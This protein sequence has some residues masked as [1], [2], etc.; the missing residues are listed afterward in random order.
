MIH[1]TA[2]VAKDVK[3][4]ESTKIWHLAQIRA[5]AIIGR[6]C[7]VGKNS[8]IGAGVKIGNY[9]KIQNNCSLYEGAE[10]E[11]GVF[12]GPH[13]VLTN[14]LN[15]RA[16]NPDGSLKSAED[17]KEGRILIKKGASIGACSVIVTGVAIGEFALVGAGS[18]VTKDVPDYALTY[19]NPAKVRGYV[20]KCGF[21]LTEEME[22]CGKCKIKLEEVRK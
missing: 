8:Y 14:D 15:P 13:V 2:E 9:V 22:E 1:S 6:N 7:I 10:L 3:I 11:D 21:K 16:I 5:N 17:W 12:I 4:D 18:V 19:G 20:C